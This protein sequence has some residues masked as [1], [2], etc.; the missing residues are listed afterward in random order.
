MKRIWIEEVESTNALL[1]REAPELEAPL[2]LLARCQTAGR[3]QRG[4]SWEAQP[5]KNL[6]FSVLFRPENFPAIRQFAIS[7][8]AAL[9]VVDFLCRYGINAKVKWANDVYAG[10]RKICGILIQHALQG[11]GIAHTVVGIGINVNQLEFLSD[12]PNPVSM[13]LLTGK[14][15]NLEQA[16]ETIALCLERR[17]TAIYDPAGRSLLH[18]EYLSRL[19]RNDGLPYLFIDRATDQRFRAVIEGVDP[20]GPISL[21]LPDGELRTYE[22]KEV[23]FVIE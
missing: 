3:G 18:E 14:S 21:R 15:Y 1:M 4:N 23:G 17:L 2:M 13:S 19:W 5:G 10:D 9:A 7:E 16:A 20:K 8:A 11:S 6:T 22:F 12:A